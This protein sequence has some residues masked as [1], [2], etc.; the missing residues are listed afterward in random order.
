[1]LNSHTVK[2]HKVCITDKKTFNFIAIMPL[3]A[4]EELCS[5]IA[6]PSDVINSTLVMMCEDHMNTGLIDCIAVLLVLHMM[7]EIYLC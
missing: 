3:L 2:V 7:I 5:L 4:R 1:M 6:L